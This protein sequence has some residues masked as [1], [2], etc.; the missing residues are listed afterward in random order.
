MVSAMM[1]VLY[2]RRMSLTPIVGIRVGD[3]VC[4]CHPRNEDDDE[5]VGMVNEEVDYDV[6]RS[7]DSLVPENRWNADIRLKAVKNA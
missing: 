1:I 4:F 2:D 6:F 3:I 7:P 5:D